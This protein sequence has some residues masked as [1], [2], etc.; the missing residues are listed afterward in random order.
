[1]NFQY[2]SI[3]CED[4]SDVRL[5][6]GGTLPVQSVQAFSKWEVGT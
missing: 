3:N 1:M 4:V 6:I 5:D 2:V